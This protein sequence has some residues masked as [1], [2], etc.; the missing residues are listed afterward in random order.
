L[1]A[2]TSKIDITLDWADFAEFYELLVSNEELKTYALE[3]Y[4]N[5]T[6]F[7]IFWSSYKK[8]RFVHLVRLEWTHY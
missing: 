4:P 3:N 8:H 2:Y 5:L 7:F 1:I 6:H